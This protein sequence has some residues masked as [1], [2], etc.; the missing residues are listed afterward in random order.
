MCLMTVTSLE[1]SCHGRLSLLE[2]YTRD[3]TSGVGT[4]YPS[5]ACEYTPVFSGI[6]V[7]QSSVFSVVFYR[8]FFVLFQLSIVLTFLLWPH[9]S[10]TLV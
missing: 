6:R 5:R 3:A 7:A 4:A 1:H 8:S 2:D 9:T 10:L